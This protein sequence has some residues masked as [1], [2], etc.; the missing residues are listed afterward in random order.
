MGGL[1]LAC[2]VGLAGAIYLVL[3]ET[4]VGLIKLATLMARQALR[5]L[6][7]ELNDASPCSLAEAR[8]AARQTLEQAEDRVW[9]VQFVKGHGGGRWDIFI[10]GG[11]I[12]EEDS[13]G[14]F[15]LRQRGGVV[16]FVAY[17]TLGTE[18]V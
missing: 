18:H 14:N 6:Y 9:S 15:T 16:E 17:D 8:A 7:G 5:E 2:V 11:Q 10:L 1:L 12:C 3:L 4:G 13:P